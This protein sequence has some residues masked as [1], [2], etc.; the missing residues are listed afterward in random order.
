MKRWILLLFAAA[1]C[2]AASV[3]PVSAGDTASAGYSITEYDMDVAVHENNVYTVTETIGVLFQD[4][5]V[6]QHGIYR[7][8]PVVTTLKRTIGDRQVN[9]TH[10][11]LITDLEISDTELGDVAYE[12]RRDGNE[13]EIKIGDPEVAVSGEHTY[14]IKYKYDVGA[15]NITEFD[16]V[17]F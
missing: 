14:I 15:D 6:A 1:A 7:N 9:K 3:G 4:G 11:A 10:Y 16:D 13:L 5:P 17:Y 12:S 8:I 2:L